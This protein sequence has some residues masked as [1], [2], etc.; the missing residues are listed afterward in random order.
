MNVKSLSPVVSIS[1][2]IPITFNPKNRN[3]LMEVSELLHRSPD[4]ILDE[5]FEDWVTCVLPV[6][7]EA[8]LVSHNE[9]LRRV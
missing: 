5:A 3:T 1:A 8:L 6:R 7:L 2:A 9:K 4:S